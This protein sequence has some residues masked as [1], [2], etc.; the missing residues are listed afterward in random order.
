M[1]RVST[2]ISP[3]RK[4]LTPSILQLE[5]NTSGNVLVSDE[6]NF[7]SFLQLT[8]RSALSQMAHADQDRNSRMFS[9]PIR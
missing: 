8:I 1:V 5:L 2:F 7:E 9:G 4:A 6:S 3:V